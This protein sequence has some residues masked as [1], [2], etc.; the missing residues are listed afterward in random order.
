MRK[1]K[2][3]DILEVKNNLLEENEEELSFEDIDEKDTTKEEKQMMQKLLHMKI[4][5]SVNR[6]KLKGKK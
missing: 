6:M 2:P 5:D 4:G 1:A 3:K